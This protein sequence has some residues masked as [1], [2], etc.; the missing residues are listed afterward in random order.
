MALPIKILF[1]T[2]VLLGRLNLPGR[3][4]ASRVCLRQRRR[5]YRACAGQVEVRGGADAALGAK[6]GKRE[7]AVSARG[8]QKVLAVRG[9]EDRVEAA[10]GASSLELERSARGQHAVHRQAH[11]PKVVARPVEDDEVES[12]RRLV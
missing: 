7:R 5:K 8:H 11:P 3:A 4:K 1:L 9:G 2:R 10:S 12:C 6:C